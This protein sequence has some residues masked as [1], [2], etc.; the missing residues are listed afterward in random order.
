MISHG[1]TEIAAGISQSDIRDIP[2][3]PPVSTPA[4]VTL[5]WSGGNIE[6][7]TW[8]DLGAQVI[9]LSGNTVKIFGAT[10]LITAEKWAQLKLELLQQGID[11]LDVSYD[12]IVLQELQKEAADPCKGR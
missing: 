10:E 11:M 8:A 2:I 3:I 9:F 6:N 7:A 4:L 1:I 5:V 12:S